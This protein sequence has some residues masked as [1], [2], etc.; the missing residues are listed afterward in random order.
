MGGF[1]NTTTGEF[2]CGAAGVY[3]E[4]GD[5]YSINNFTLAGKLDDIFKNLILADDL[6]FKYSKNSPT[7]FINE[8]LVV[9]GQ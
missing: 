4:N 7:A 3:F 6:K 9:G 1:G 8:G 5:N 2:S